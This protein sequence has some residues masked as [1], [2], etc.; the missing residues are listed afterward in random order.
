LTITAPFAAL[1]RRRTTTLISPRTSTTRPD[2]VRVRSDGPEGPAPHTADHPLRTRS[3]A[4]AP[5]PSSRLVALP[6]LDGRLPTNPADIDVHLAELERA[7]QCQ[8]DAL[9]ECPNNVV[10][11]AHR[12]VVEHLLAEVRAARE[13]IR[14]G[15]YGRCTRC[16]TA[17]ETAALE[18]VPW[19]P[20][21]TTC[22]T[23][24]P[25]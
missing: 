11:A 21:C 14:A 1:T 18:R 5:G 15:A 4:Q 19:Q 25:S 7:R 10:T 8:L 22:T 24:R 12:R 3:D 17:V 16:R 2:Q 23:P 20:T 9:P 6:Q 13:R